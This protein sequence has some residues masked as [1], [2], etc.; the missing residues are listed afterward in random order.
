MYRGDV[1]GEF[2]HYGLQENDE[3][4]AVIILIL[5]FFHQSALISME[6]IVFCPAT[7]TLI[8]TAP[9]FHKLLQNKLGWGGV[10]GHRF[11]II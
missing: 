6:N 1:N 10:N 11:A 8:I 2:K 5:R 7:I 9:I 4:W 3:K